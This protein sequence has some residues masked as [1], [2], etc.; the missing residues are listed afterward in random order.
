MKQNAFPE[1]ELVLKEEN[2][3]KALERH[4]TLNYL[5]TFEL[6]R[7]TK[8]LEKIKLYNSRFKTQNYHPEREGK[9]KFFSSEFHKNHLNA[10]LKS[11][12]WI[13]LGQV[14]PR[15]DEK[16]QALASHWIP[17]LSRSLASSEELA[18]I[19]ENKELEALT[20][21]ATAAWKEARWK[22][23]FDPANRGI[24]DQIKF[25]LRSFINL[26]HFK[27]EKN[28]VIN[29]LL[30][31][32]H[33]ASY[34]ENS[35]SDDIVHYVVTCLKNLNVVQQLC[36][37]A[38]GPNG[39]HY[40]TEKQI[41]QFL[42]KPHY[43]NMNESLYA[44]IIHQIENHGSKRQ[45]LSLQKFP[46]FNENTKI[47][48]TRN[49][50][51][52]NH[53]FAVPTFL[54]DYIPRYKPWPVWLFRNR[55]FF[56]Q[57]FR[58]KQWFLQIMKTEALGQPEGEDLIHIN[59]PSLEKIRWARNIASV[60]ANKLNEEIDEIK[61][62]Q[63]KIFLKKW[64]ECVLQ[65]K[66]NLDQKIKSE[67]EVLESVSIAI[68]SSPHP[69]ES[70]MEM[71]STSVNV[72]LF[73]GLNVKQKK[74]LDTFYRIN[75]SKD[76]GK[77][78]Q[79][80]VTSL[81]KQAHL[82]FLESDD[83]FSNECSRYVN[84]VFFAGLGAYLLNHSIQ[85]WMHKNQ[86]ERRLFMTSLFDYFSLIKETRVKE[87][88]INFIVPFT[89]ILINQL[90]I[91]CENIIHDSSLNILSNEMVN[92]WHAYLRDLI[93]VSEKNFQ[94]KI[95]VS[96]LCKELTLITNPHL[97]EVKCRAILEGIANNRLSPASKLW[98]KEKSDD[99]HFT[100]S[101]SNLTNRGPL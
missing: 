96:T 45:V 70:F 39:Q 36:G 82:S 95:F 1:I 12:T 79:K 57:Y 3:I 18:G 16:I 53:L 26:N 28:R 91:V 19:L 67:S 50:S 85:N 78:K 34:S 62:Q 74:I 88:G 43:C 48:P 61:S 32:L 92:H 84:P 22:R 4:G 20:E 54:M 72:K 59:Q 24:Y 93:L 9:T 31:R 89:K 58:K 80:E 52:K 42:K 8:F 64:Q 63:S 27:T 47:L 98:K 37:C 81:L 94:L 13:A 46:V 101:H 15:E 7:L 71:N 33:V 66:E 65:F 73:N 76:I 11:S 38:L 77:L 60:E 6:H 86:E 23:I 14:N 44:K 56:Y 83:F 41:T 29:D 25:Y 51:R 30:A 69:V 17:R 10:L 35:T 100:T 21:F 40:L 90:K 55:H 99:H 87:Y 49:L 97:L 5:K 75:N 68:P 2:E